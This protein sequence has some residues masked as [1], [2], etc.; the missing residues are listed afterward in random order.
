[1]YR[2]AQLPQGPLHATPAVHKFG[3]NIQIGTMIPISTRL[4]WGV[5]RIF[6]WR[7]KAA[8][9]LC[10]PWFRD[11]LEMLSQWY[12]RW[13]WT[14]WGRWTRSNQLAKDMGLDSQMKLKDQLCNQ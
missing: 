2:S 13:L 10:A 6:F 9:C 14:S 3:I 5:N 7:A 4:T 8:W 12:L 11:C 1:M